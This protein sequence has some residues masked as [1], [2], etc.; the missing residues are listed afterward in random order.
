MNLNSIH[1]EASQFLGI[2][3]ASEP[4]QKSKFGGH[5]ERF[6]KQLASQANRASHASD[7]R[8]ISVR[9]PTEESPPVVPA[10]MPLITREVSA[11]LGHQR[12]A[13]QQI[14]PTSAEIPEKKT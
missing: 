14:I 9:V 12:F 1:L 4:P 6:F 3:F 13:C 8:T 5:I 2:T 10:L 7:A 11:R